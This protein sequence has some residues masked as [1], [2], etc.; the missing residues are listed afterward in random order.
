MEGVRSFCDLAWGS[1]TGNIYKLYY[2][3]SINLDIVGFSVSYIGFRTIVPV[4]NICRRGVM[5]IG[6]GS[7]ANKIGS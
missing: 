3:Y 2:T 4:S 5:G 1:D 7:H 6:E